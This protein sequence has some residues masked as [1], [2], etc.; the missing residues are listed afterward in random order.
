MNNYNNKRRMIN[1]EN[2]YTHKNK[3]HCSQEDLPRFALSEMSNK[4]FKKVSNTTIFEL[5]NNNMKE[6]FQNNNLSFFEI[7]I[8]SKKDENYSE[9]NYLSLEE[10]KN[11]DDLSLV[12]NQKEQYIKCIFD[13]RTNFQIEENFHRLNNNGNH[14]N[15]FNILDNYKSTNILLIP[16]EILL[17][18]FKKVEPHLWSKNIQKYGLVCKKWYKLLKDNLFSEEEEEL[19]FMYQNEKKHFI[20]NNSLYDYIL[21]NKHEEIDIK[22]RSILVDW[23]ILV[24]EEFKLQSETLFLCIS[25]IDRYLSRTENLKRDIFQLLGIACLLIASKYEDLNP[26]TVTDLSYISDGTYSK[27]MIIEMEMEILNILKFDLVISTTKHFLQYFL[28]KIKKKIIT[29]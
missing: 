17:N 15:N 29:L 16:D 27:E 5:T 8:S 19:K 18:I 11:G 21:H 6:N 7:K 13:P 10:V 3:I 12:W 20:F 2:D 4:Q 25:Y 24:T 1:D 9:T 14:N 28:D 22:M 26:P 23:L